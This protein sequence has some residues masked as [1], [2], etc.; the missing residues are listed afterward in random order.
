MRLGRVFDPDDVHLVRREGQ[1]TG[2]AAEGERKG[3][4][5]PRNDAG[6]RSQVGQHLVDGAGRFADH[7]DLAGLGQAWKYSRQAYGTKEHF[8][9]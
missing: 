8:I 4:W 1:K 3:L 6:Q 5:I 7:D 9:S 2:L